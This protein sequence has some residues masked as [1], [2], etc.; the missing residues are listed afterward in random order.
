M[1]V[2]HDI[3]EALRRPIVWVLMDHGRS[4]P[5]KGTPLELLTSS[6]ATIL[7]VNFCRKELGV[8]ASRCAKS[9]TIWS[10]G[11]KSVVKPLHDG[12]S[13]RDALS[14]FSPG[15]EV[16]YPFRTAGTPCGTIH[17]AICWRG[18]DA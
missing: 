16:R 13:L 17:F 8:M 5:A 14:A 15:S 10:G 1:L 12:M 11:C 7:V 18:G 6:P 9:R 4:R 3:D 2:T